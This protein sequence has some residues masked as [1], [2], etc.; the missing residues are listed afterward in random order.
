MFDPK[1]PVQTNEDGRGVTAAPAQ[2]PTHRYSFVNV[3]SHALRNGF[4]FEKEARSPVGK[5]LLA[6][7]N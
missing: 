7:G 2:A 3:D 1:K 4:S 5:I 6:A